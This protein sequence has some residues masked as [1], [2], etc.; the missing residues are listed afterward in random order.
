MTCAFFFGTFYCHFLTQLVAIIARYAA[1]IPLYTPAENVT[2]KHDMFFGDLRNP[3]KVHEQRPHFLYGLPELARDAPP[4]LLPLLENC[5]YDELLPIDGDVFNDDHRLVIEELISALKPF[6]SFKSP[7]YND[8]GKREGHGRFEYDNGDVYEGQ[9]VNSLR[10]GYGKL[11]CASGGYTYRGY[12]KNDLRHGRGYCEEKSYDTVIMPR[13]VI[14]LKPKKVTST[15]TS[16]KSRKI[17]PNMKRNKMGGRKTKYG[18]ENLQK[19]NV[20]DKAVEMEEVEELEDVEEVRVRV[21]TYDGDWDN[22]KKNGFGKL[23]FY[24]YNM[25][26]H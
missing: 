24:V 23:V 5:W 14:K 21:S 1:N 8:E 16:T 6:L 20:N 26:C 25:L 7:K 4:V 11:T 12:W 9:C 18:Q 17:Q 10:D 2:S 22:D 19:A 15:V 3:L 13:K